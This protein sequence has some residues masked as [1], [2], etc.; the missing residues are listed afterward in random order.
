MMLGIK[1]CSNRYR[2]LKRFVFII[3]LIDVG[4]MLVSKRGYFN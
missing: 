4:V 1:F 2:D 3:L